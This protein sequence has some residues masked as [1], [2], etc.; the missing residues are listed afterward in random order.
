MFP[1]LSFPSLLATTLKSPP[2]HSRNHGPH[3]YV[4]AGQKPSQGPKLSYAV[5][6]GRNS[7]ARMHREMDSSSEMIRK[8]VE[9][10]REREKKE[11]RCSEV[12]RKRKTQRFWGSQRHKDTGEKDPEPGLEGSYFL[13]WE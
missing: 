5:G 8:Q 10:K 3:P 12:Q 9:K 1:E 13:V 6:K 2:V 11:N 4:W 7:K